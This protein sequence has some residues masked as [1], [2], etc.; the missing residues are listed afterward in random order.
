MEIERGLPSRKNTDSQNIRNPKVY[1]Q[2]IGLYQS[3]KS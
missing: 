1:V 3:L 2:S